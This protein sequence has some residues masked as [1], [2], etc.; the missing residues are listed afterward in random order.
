VL[1]QVHDNDLPAAMALG[2]LGSRRLDGPL[3][4][5]SGT[6]QAMGLVEEARQLGEKRQIPPQGCAPA[7]VVQLGEAH[8]PYGPMV[9]AS[10][11]GA[12][13]MAGPQ[14]MMAVEE[15]GTENRRPEDVPMGDRS[16]QGVAIPD[17]RFLGA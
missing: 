17:G 8:G 3:G 15:P 9:A 16:G 13:P 11:A 10:Q 12:V 6:R 1:Q 4:L 5:V 7:S 14:A 2:G